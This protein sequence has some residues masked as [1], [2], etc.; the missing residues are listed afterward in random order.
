MVVDKE[1][2]EKM[3]NGDKLRQ[4]SDAELYDNCLYMIDCALC[5]FWKRCDNSTANRISI[6]KV[7]RKTWMDWLSEEAK[8][9]ER[10]Q[11]SADV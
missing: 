8:N 2:V 4:M 7:C 6:Y 10:G 3:T 5:D 9:D 1:E 11:D